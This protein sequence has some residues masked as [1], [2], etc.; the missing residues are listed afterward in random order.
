MVVPEAA[1]PGVEGLAV[2]HREIR[3]GLERQLAVE[4][5]VTARTAVITGN[6][7]MLLAAAAA[8]LVRRAKPIEAAAMVQMDGST[9]HTLHRLPL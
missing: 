2:A 6:Q 8:G 5:A 7:A 3:E 4:P 1:A 9:S